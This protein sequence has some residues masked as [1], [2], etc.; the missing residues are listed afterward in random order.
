MKNPQEEVQ[1]YTLWRIHRRVDYSLWRN[2]HFES[3]HPEKKKICVVVGCLIASIELLA[4]PRKRTFLSMEI[5]WLEFCCWWMEFVPHSL[6]DFCTPKVPSFVQLWVFFCFDL[7][8]VS[9]HNCG[10]LAL[11]S[12]LLCIWRSASEFC[13]FSKLWRL[14]STVKTFSVHRERERERERERVL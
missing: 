5:L 12:L 13:V 1:I 3:T 9:L 4:F 7:S 10:C 14:C 8:F 11:I 2:P 6:I